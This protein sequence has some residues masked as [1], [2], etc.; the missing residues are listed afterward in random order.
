MQLETVHCLHAQLAFQRLGFLCSEIGQLK[1]PTS[2]SE[3]K[4]NSSPPRIS[5]MESTRT[6]DK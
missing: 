1:S 2:T 5:V 3:S 4:E 6:P